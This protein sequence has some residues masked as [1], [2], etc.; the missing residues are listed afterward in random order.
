MST[1]VS[2]PGTIDKFPIPGVSVKGA[3][4]DAAPDSVLG[5]LRAAHREHREQETITLS[6]PPF[7]GLK[8]RVTYGYVSVDDME[9]VDTS[10]MSN[11][12]ATLK[13]MA[14]ACQAIEV[15]DEQADKWEVLEDNIGPVSFDDRY[16]RLMQWE[17]PGEGDDFVFPTRQV[18]DVVFNH[19]GMALG[20]HIARAVDFMAG[21]EED[22]AALLGEASTLGRITPGSRSR[23]A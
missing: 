10:G 12:D 7:A 23:S 19:N 20:M 21:G 13:L 22:V 18:Y 15:Y 8:R 6:L 3:A 9:D 4:G 16:A 17:R 1:S 11:M 5:Q 2:G 14:R